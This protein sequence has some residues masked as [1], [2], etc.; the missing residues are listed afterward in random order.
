MYEAI[1]TWLE[2]IPEGNHLLAIP[3]NGQYDLDFFRAWTD[4]QNGSPGDY[5]LIAM[6][7]TSRS[8]QAMGYVINNLF[9]SRVVYLTYCEDVE[10]IMHSAF[11][12]P[13]VIEKMSSIH[14]LNGGEIIE[15]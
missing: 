2:N 1:K 3:D 8:D 6:R 4:F 11:S 15:Y 7:K 13:P 14:Y 12:Q 5:Q 9:A 10:F